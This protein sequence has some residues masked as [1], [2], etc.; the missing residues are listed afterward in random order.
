MATCP[1][2]SDAVLQTL[3]RAFPYLHVAVVVGT[4]IA[5]VLIDVAELVPMVRV[6]IVPVEKIDD[7]RVDAQAVVM[8]VTVTVLAVALVGVVFALVND[9]RRSGDG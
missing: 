5:V 8:D 1:A 7:M 3:P 6:V 9:E 2:L 4:V